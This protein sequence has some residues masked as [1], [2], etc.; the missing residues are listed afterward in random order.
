[1]PGGVNSLLALAGLDVFR[2]SN[3]NSVFILVWALWFLGRS[4]Q[5]WTLRPIVWRFALPVAIAAFGIVDSLPWINFPAVLRSHMAALRDA[6]SLTAQLEA[7]LGEGARI[8]QIPAPAFPEAGSIGQMTD[9]EH[10]LPFL[11]SRSLRFSY[12]ALRGT[13]LADALTA[14]AHT[15]P[16]LMRETLES[17]GFS[18]V[19]IDRRGLPDG[20]KALVDTFRS[21]H[22]AEIPQTTA[23]NVVIFALNP[24]PAPAPFDTIDPR[25]YP[26]WDAATP[27]APKVA[28]VDGWYPLEHA[29]GRSWRWAERAATLSLAVPTPTAVEFSFRAYSLRPG[30]LALELDGAEVWRESSSSKTRL[31]RHVTF[32]LKPGTHRLVWR[33]HGPLRRAS[34]TDRRHLGFAIEN[35]TLR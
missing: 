10:F 35:L 17:V 2:A 27:T 30:Q 9:Y 31:E 22:L 1:M 19:W 3:R 7:R 6:R 16:A 28:A 20:G 21:L 11:T 5:R 29:D 12:G 24:A 18:A 15:P 25:L 34:P 4:V 26:A 32:S 33:F 13:E 14:L 23:P 8:F